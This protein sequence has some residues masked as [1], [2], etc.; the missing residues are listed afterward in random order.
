MMRFGFKKYDD[1]V[2]SKQEHREA[3]QTSLKGLI[4]GKWLAEKI[5]GNLHFV[6]FLAVLG[7][8]YIANG[9]HVERLYKRKVNLEKEVGNLRAESISTSAELVFKRKQSEVIKRMEREGL[10]LEPSTIPPIKL[11][12]S[13]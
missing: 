12:R 13:R 11:K 1:F 6:V 9:Y 10:E 2:P 5:Q 7:I 3:S 4:G 8:L